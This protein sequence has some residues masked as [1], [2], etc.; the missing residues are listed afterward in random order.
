MRP[1][2]L[3]AMA[4]LA[5]ALLAGGS[6]VAQTQ[7]TLLRWL[8]HGFF[9]LATR[10]GIKVA[11]DPFEPS[12]LGYALPDQISANVA[13]ITRESNLSGAT[14]RL[15]GN[16]EVFRSTTAT[17]INRGSG[18]TF[19]G[20]STF[21]DPDR[22]ALGGRNIVFV[23]EADGIRFAFAGVLNDRLSKQALQTAGTV[24]V[25]VAGFGPRLGPAGLLAT[26]NDLGAKVIIPAAYRTPFSGRADAPDIAP[27]ADQA[28]RFE[29][30]TIPLVKADLPKQTEVW[31]P[32]IPDREKRKKEG[33]EFPGMR[34][35]TWE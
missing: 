33:I 3:I 27:L 14:W 1:P 19:V 12:S 34:E 23:F 2:P 24:D 20:I 6:S 4:A 7:P 29:T 9:V 15:A 32:A 35:S 30:T 22:A 10:N 26:A 5:S 17:G 28:R 25:L 11:V 16:P 8:G 31:M 13:L 21:I 18:L